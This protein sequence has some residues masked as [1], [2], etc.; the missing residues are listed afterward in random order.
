[1]KMLG[2]DYGKSKLGLAIAE[3]FLASPLKVIKK[4]DEKKLIK[5]IKQERIE[6]IIV[7]VSE[8]EMAKESKKFAH[9][10]SKKVNV[11]IEFEDETLSTQDAQR[12]SQEAGIKR[13]K[14]KRL[15][16]AYSAALILQSYLDKL[17]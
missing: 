11:P 1:M 8:G 10:L 13:S 12:L 14:R 2:I 16:D 15:E 3:S 7:G 9:N 4:V 17:V 6:K 5:I